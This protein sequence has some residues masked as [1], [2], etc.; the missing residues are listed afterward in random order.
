MI[1]VLSF[2]LGH[3]ILDENAGRDV[4]IQRRAAIPMPGVVE[5]LPKITVPMALWANTQEASAGDVKQWLGRAGLERHFRWVVT[6]SD[7][8]Y[9]KPDPRF[10]AAA[11]K[12]CGCNADELLFI[13]NQKNTDIHGANLCGIQ[14]VLLTG[15]F[16]RSVDDADD[17][18]AEPT[19]T[20]QDLG[21]L[22]DLLAR[23]GIQIRQVV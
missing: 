23:L 8:G 6:S 19:H 4:D 10:F 3:T 11:L 2:D 17:S 12:E 20:I 14:S 1:R 21:E 18:T 13:G 5:V 9:R 16:Y 15:S 22:P 7:I